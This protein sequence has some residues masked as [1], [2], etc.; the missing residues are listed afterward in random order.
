[1]QSRFLTYKKSEEFGEC[2]RNKE[3][4]QELHK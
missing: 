2:D 1:M 4:I 3:R